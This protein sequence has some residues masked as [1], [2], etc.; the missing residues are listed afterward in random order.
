MGQVATRT[1]DIPTTT[2]LFKTF[3]GTAERIDMTCKICSE[4]YKDPK[5]LPCLDTFCMKCIQKLCNESASKKVTCP[6]CKM[7][8]FRRENK[9]CRYDTNMYFLNLLQVL[10]TRVDKKTPCHVCFAHGR[11]QNNAT[12]KCLE[13]SDYLCSFCAKSHTLTKYTISHTVVALDDLQCGKYDTHV[14]H[15]QK[16]LCPYHT[17]EEMYYFCQSC[18]MAVC[19]K[20]VL[21]DH[22]GHN[23]TSLADSCIY[24]LQQLILEVDKRY[25]TLQSDLIKEQLLKKHL[26]D[27]KTKFMKEITDIADDIV[28]AVVKEKNEALNEV[29]NSFALPIKDRFKKIQQLM[30]V[31][32]IMDNS[33][34]FCKTVL[35]HGKEIEILSLEK[36]LRQQLLRLQNF[37]AT[38]DAKK[39]NTDL[40]IT[41]VTLKELKKDEDGK[42]GVFTL[43]YTDDSIGDLN[44]VS[45][46]ASDCSVLTSIK[47]TQTE[48]PKQLSTFGTGTQTECDKKCDKSTQTYIKETQTTSNDVTDNVDFSRLPE[49][50]TISIHST[51]DAKT[52]YADG[53]SKYNNKTF[54]VYDYLNKTLKSFDF[55]GKFK[56]SYKLDKMVPSYIT[57]CG[58]TIVISDRLKVVFMSKNKTWR[59]DISVQSNR[60]SIPLTS[61]G[62]R[63]I[64]AG[65]VDISNSLP[66]TVFTDKGDFVKSIHLDNALPIHLAANTNGQIIMSDWKKNAIRIVDP[67]VG[68][69]IA[70][71]KA[72]KESG[73]RKWNKDH[74]KDL[75]RWR[76]GSLATD[77]RDNIYVLD[78]DIGAILTLDKDGK[79]VKETLTYT[80]SIGIG[81]P[82]YLASDAK[83]RLFIIGNQR[84][85]AHVFNIQK[86]LTTE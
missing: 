27:N 45:E 35:H 83:Q 6:V 64:V 13:C 68:T 34:R 84:D 4:I 23:H 2:L 11:L 41:S 69:E 42:I 75:T 8:L 52:P 28:A 16:M 44:V 36:H 65:N 25:E 29:E 48:F 51:D 79:F 10:K 7:Q 74:G 22:K 67:E 38:P 33:I 46:T 76:P 73:I 53:I 59:R 61:F 15:I 20:C 21:V 5:I 77:L 55:K 72:P 3:N 66:L 82:G 81:K 70:C 54:I 37:D 49:K 19:K 58:N 57:A 31:I 80:K 43:T 62:E 32:S 14:R 39:L 63:F 50:Y 78:Y 40:P 47:S 60:E 86:F 17:N 18:S 1:R 9:L 56:T 26:Q 24:S 30:H 12:T 85:V 71:I